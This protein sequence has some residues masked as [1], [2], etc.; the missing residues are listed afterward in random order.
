MRKHRPELTSDGQTKRTGG[1]LSKGQTLDLRP[2]W[3]KFSRSPIGRNNKLTGNEKVFTI[4]FYGF[5]FSYSAF[6]R[7]GKG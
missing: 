4:G 5:V 6:F 3:T 2:N 1:S 7:T